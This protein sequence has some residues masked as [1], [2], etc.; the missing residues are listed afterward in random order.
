MIA[1]V[2]NRLGTYDD[3]DDDDD[4][5]NDDHHYHRSSLYVL[6]HLCIPSHAP[7][8]LSLSLTHT[9]SSGCHNLSLILSAQRALM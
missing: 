4:D 6:L 5:D 9:H 1:G 7:F 2:C 8:Y 3:D